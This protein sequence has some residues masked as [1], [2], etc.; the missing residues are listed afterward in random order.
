MKWLQSL[1][2]NK[3]TSIAGLALFGLEVAAI[4]LPQHKDKF[5]QVSKLAMMYGLVMSSDSKA[6]ASSP[7]PEMKSTSLEKDL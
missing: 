3:H 4:F 5:E 1:I 2:E 7:T 6:K